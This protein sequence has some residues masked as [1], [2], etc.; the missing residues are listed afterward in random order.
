MS[1]QNVEIVRDQ[2]DATNERDFRRVMSHYA[3]DVEMVVPFGLRAGTFKGRRAVGEWFGDWLATFDEDARFDIEEIVG[4]GAL[5]LLIARHRATGR[6]SGVAVARAVCWVYR[7]EAG[8]IKL[9][10]AYESRDEARK[11]VGLEG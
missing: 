5:V 10:Q 3:E 4:K 1:Q 6:A 8:K 7:I 11:A 2:Y 9:V